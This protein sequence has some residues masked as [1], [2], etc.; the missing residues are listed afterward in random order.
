M[1]ET[2]FW[3]ESR[4]MF[5]L[6]NDA[7]VA[8]SLQQKDYSARRGRFYLFWNIIKTSGRPTLVA[9]MA[10]DAAYQTEQ[11]SN[12]SLIAEATTRLSKMFPAQKVPTPSEAIVTRWL[13]DPFSGGSYSY[14]GPQTQP[15]DYDVMAQPWGNIHFAGEATC[16]THP[17]TVHGAYLSGLRAAAEVI[18]DLIGAVTVPQPLFPP[19]IKVGETPVH[20]APKRKLEYTEEYYIPLLD[21]KPIIDIPGKVEAEAYEASIIGAILTRIGDRPIKPIK[22][23]VNPF[24][25]YQKDYWY[26]CKAEADAAAQRKTRKADAKASKQ[27]IRLALGNKWR[28]EA[29]EVRK[30]YLDAAQASR[31]GIASLTADFKERVRKWDDDAARIREE[32]IAKN[33]P[34][35]GAEKYLSG[36]TAIELGKMRRDKQL[37]GEDAAAPPTQEDPVFN[38]I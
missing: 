22:Q 3:E 18:D 5:G 1:Y 35:T 31:D 23:G 11:E 2:P 27:E 38:A 20:A 32:F 15:G 19:K 25:L 13:R 34:P 16:G 8:E 17:A 28:T 21:Q 36:R 10:G 29:E 26:K 14:V 30:P 24:L 7:E 33:A 9:L 4:D 12:E 6:L 37:M